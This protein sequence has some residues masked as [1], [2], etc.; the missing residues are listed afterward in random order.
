MTQ[1][2]IYREGQP[3]PDAQRLIVLLP[4][5]SV[6]SLALGRRIWDL[7]R[8]HR[9]RIL[10]LSLVRDYDEELAALHKMSHLA[11]IVQDTFTKAETLVRISR[12]WLKEVGT[13]WK[14]GDLLICFADQTVRSRLFRQET[15][16]EFLADR[17]GIPVYMISNP[18][19]A[20]DSL[21]IRFGNVLIK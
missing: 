13:T 17:L 15:L 16:G 2:R 18:I 5:Y 7:A 4:N 3:L 9:S 12:N 21:P 14:P 20:P 10:F 6:D 1:T 11:A 19:S 8:V